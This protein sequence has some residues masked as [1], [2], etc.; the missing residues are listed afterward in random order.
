LVII[1]LAI[2]NEND[3]HLDMEIHKKPQYFKKIWA[4]LFIGGM[5]P[6]LSMADTSSK[7]HLYHKRIEL[8]EI[9]V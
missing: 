3:Y 7:D 5:L 6:S 8:H 4:Y 2:L 9:E 1:F